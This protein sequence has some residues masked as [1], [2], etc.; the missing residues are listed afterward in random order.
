MQQTNLKIQIMVH[1][2][3]IVGIVMCFGTVILAFITITNYRLKKKLIESGQLD[4]E[5]QKLITQ[6][7]SGMKFDNLKWGLILL[8][9]GLGMVVID[10]L[11]VDKIRNFHLQ[12]GIE[13]IFI[14]VGFLIYFFYMKDRKVD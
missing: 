4:A 1:L 10:F 7:F 5:S 6:N 14:A 11:P 12:M 8:F 13:L 3:P 9:A 2:I